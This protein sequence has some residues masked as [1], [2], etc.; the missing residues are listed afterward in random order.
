MTPPWLVATL[1]GAGLALVSSVH[2]L[3]MC[4]PLTAA[5]QARAG[6]GAGPRYLLGRLASYSVVGLLSG[7]VGQAVLSTRWARWGEAV[8]AWTLSLLLLRSAFGFFGWLH[9]TDLLSIGRGPRR[10]WAGRLL[11]RVATDPLLLGAA[12]A[13]LPCA[14]LFAA[15]VASAAL[16]SGAQGALFMMSFA[17]VTSPALLGGAQLGRL[18]QRGERA[19]RVLGVVLVAG[20]LITALRPLSTLHAESQPSCPLHDQ[21]TE[22]P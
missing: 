2:C 10:T 12:T 14:A 16:G 22:A 8:L 5:S 19:R 7:S 11:A 21:H 15:I 9:R 20:A 6:S 17:I 4:G 13:L 3:T 1:A 18:A